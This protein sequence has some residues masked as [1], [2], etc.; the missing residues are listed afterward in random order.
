MKAL[1]SKSTLQKASFD[2]LK[3]QPSLYSR[4]LFPKQRFDHGFD[5][6]FY[7]T[8]KKASFDKRLLDVKINADVPKQM[9]EKSKKDS[10]IWMSFPGRVKGGSVRHNGKSG[11]ELEHYTWDA[12]HGDI[13]AFNHLGHHLG[14]MHPETGELYQP[15]VKGR[16]IK[17]N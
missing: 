16:K 2:F 6:R 15:A 17:V 1:A 13:E 9:W 3:H 10:P 8:K 5:K 4:D 12:A 14:S 7:G 11:S